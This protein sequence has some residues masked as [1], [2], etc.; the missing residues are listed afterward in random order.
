MRKD[1]D[2]TQIDRDQ[3]CRW[4]LILQPLAEN[5][6]LHGILEKEDKYG[7]IT[8]CAKRVNGEVILEVVDDGVGMSEEEL[9]RLNEVMKEGG[10]GV[11]NVSEKIKLYYGTRYGLTFISEKYKGTTATVRIPA[12]FDKGT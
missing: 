7:G 3:R 9:I 8:I 10:Y 2:E 1:G 6:I 4:A 5:A 11:R 12:I